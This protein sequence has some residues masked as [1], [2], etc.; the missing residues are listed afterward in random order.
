[1]TEETPSPTSPADTPLEPFTLAVK[2]TVNIDDAMTDEQI[3][4]LP[5]SPTICGD[6]DEVVAEVPTKTVREDTEKL[7][8]ETVSA[9]KDV[10]AAQK[11][12][13][14]AQTYQKPVVNASGSWKSFRQR[15]VTQASK[16]EEDNTQTCKNPVVE[17]L[18]SK[19]SKSETPPKERTGWKL[20]PTLPAPT[21]TMTPLPLEGTLKPIPLGQ[22]EFPI[23]MKLDETEDKDMKN[24]PDAGRQT[25]NDGGEDD[26]AKKLAR[27]KELRRKRNLREAKRKAR[28]RANKRQEQTMQVKEEQETN[29][30]QDDA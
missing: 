12:E 23:P 20:C 15:D 26:V 5:I 10:H 9:P 21:A 14:K 28:K 3:A 27:L 16:K 8:T 22:P 29:S 4:A 17:T 6:D 13:D 1:M 7:P 24:E 30:E 18:G 2:D 11:E 25:G 19:K